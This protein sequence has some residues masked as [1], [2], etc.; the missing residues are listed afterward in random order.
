MGTEGHQSSSRVVA[1]P[2]HRNYYTDLSTTVFNGLSKK[3]ELPSE[4]QEYST[5]GDYSSDSTESCSCIEC[6]A[7]NSDTEEE[8]DSDS[9]YNKFKK[10]LRQ[11]KW[12]KK[13]I[14]SFF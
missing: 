4:E 7:H 6:S 2:N 5:E 9:R 11:K 8:D 14:F 12:L 1:Q 10:T 13:G 3:E